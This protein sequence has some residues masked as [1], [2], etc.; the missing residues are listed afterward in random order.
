MASPSFPLAPGWWGMSFALLL[1]SASLCCFTASQEPKGQGIMSYFQ[2][3]ARTKLFSERTISD[4]SLECWKADAHG[5]GARKSRDCHSAGGRWW[6]R[7]K[8][9][10][11]A[12]KNSTRKSATSRTFFFLAG[13]AIH[14][15]AFSWAP[16]F[17]ICERKTHILQIN[18]ELSWVSKR[19][20]TSSHF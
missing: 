6:T 1:A 12:G 13:D 2:N 8:D 5:G 10:E 18:P 19:W 9:A 3:R 17:L 4:V 16:A 7:L 11:H 15:I 14:T 20:H